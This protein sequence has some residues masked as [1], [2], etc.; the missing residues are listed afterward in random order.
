MTESP[1][2]PRHFTKAVTQLGEQR[3]VVT[4]A[5][6]F[7]AQG[8][9][10]IDKGVAINK[11]LYQRLT[12]HRLAVPL[13]DSVTSPDAVNGE[14]LKQTALSIMED[15]PFFGRLAPD[16]P[17]RKLLLNVMETLPL[18]EAMAF[19]LTVARDVR[20]EVYMN[21]VRTALVA[22]W[23]AKSQ[24]T[25]LSR[26]DLGMAGSAGLLHDIGMLHVDPILLEGTQRLNREQRRQLYS[27]P[28][29][30]TTLV[31]RH[32]QYS[33]EV[34]RAVSEHQEYLDG[35]GYPRNLLG[36]AMSPLGRVV[37]LAQ[38]VAAMFSPMRNAPEM[39]LSVLLR[40]N[41]HRY[42]PTM[43]MQILTLVQPQLDVL[44]AAIELLDDP[45]QLLGEIDAI[46]ARLP[47]DLDKDPSM[48][49]SRRDALATVA[50]HGAKLRRSLAGV[51]A[52]PDQLAQLGDSV[53]DEAVRTELTLLTREACWQLRTLGREARRRWREVPDESY[54][55]LLRG[56]LDDVDALVARLA[57]P[58]A[59]DVPEAI[60]S[61]FPQEA[62][63]TEETPAP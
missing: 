23:L 6:I 37:S 39:Q 40:M 45:V 20:P 46:L 55:A 3:D 61:E 50:G 58:S 33:R 14:S 21:L 54:P 19:Q 10:V 48:N 17:S 38:V 25:M 35:S 44:S 11:S 13:E 15:V 52:V 42:D 51:G 1:E 57:G 36:E 4:A 60:S 34:I 30:S 43:S 26:F 31:E 8:I 24:A 18:P 2:D 41:T 7:N 47:L 63:P 12:Q 5:A 56:W 59:T 28:L 27:H 29:V 32:H 22:I 16:V 9:K 53:Q 62:S 49:A